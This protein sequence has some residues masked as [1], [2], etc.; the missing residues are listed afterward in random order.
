MIN[1]WSS[2]D[3]LTDQGLKLAWFGVFV[4]CLGLIVSNAKWLSWFGLAGTAVGLVLRHRAEHLKKTQSAPRK[5]KAGEIAKILEAL[6]HV[7]K[8]PLSVGFFG[9]DLEAEQYAIQIKVALESAGFHVVR[10]EG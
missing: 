5:L 9:Q 4:T 3:K 7:P 10:L 8:Q 6:A 1:F 2:T